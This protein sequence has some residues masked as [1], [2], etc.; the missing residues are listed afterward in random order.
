IRKDGS[1]VPIDDSAAPIRERDGKVHGCVLVF[2]DISERKAAER[3]LHDAQSRLARVVADMAIPTMVYADDGE[4][5]LVNRA[6]T[7][8]SGFAAGDLKTIPAWT[9]HA[10]GARA[11]AMNEVIASLFDLAE[12]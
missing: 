2:R 9:K 4:V 7:R 6:W 3:N 5:I 8:I 11:E 10:Y 1:E 12:A